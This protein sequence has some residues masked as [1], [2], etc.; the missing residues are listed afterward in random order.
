MKEI[1]CGLV[2]SC[3]LLECDN[4][5]TCDSKHFYLFVSWAQ[6]VSVANTHI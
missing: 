2:A 6:E 4:F 3:A 1:P 5:L